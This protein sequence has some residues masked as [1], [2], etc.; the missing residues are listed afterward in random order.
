MG[1]EAVGVIQR[2]AVDREHGDGSAAN[3]AVAVA[4]HDA[5]KPTGKSGWV[6]QLCQ[7]Q[8]GVQKGLLRDILCQPWITHQCIRAGIGHILE[9]VDD[10]SKGIFVTLLGGYD[11]Y[12]EFGHL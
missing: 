11:E 7:V 8:I 12:A 6:A 1:I 5:A 2:Q 10:L 3:L 9:T 4:Q